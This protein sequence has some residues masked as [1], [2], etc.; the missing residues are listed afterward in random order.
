MSKY[1]KL[2]CNDV[3]PL[4]SWY[5]ILSGYCIAV[6]YKSSSFFMFSPLPKCKGELSRI[7][8]FSVWRP[9][10]F[11]LK[12]RR[13]MLVFTI[14]IRIRIIEQKIILKGVSIPPQGTLQYPRKKCLR[15]ILF[16]SKKTIA[17]W[18]LFFR[19]S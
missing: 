18:D 4:R 6:Q 10:G 13:I 14:Y 11:C 9:F 19:S 16:L 3:H 15:R 2:K 5:G 8:E 1:L 17:R 12:N 7:S